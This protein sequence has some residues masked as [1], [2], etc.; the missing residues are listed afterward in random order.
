M[1]LICAK[2]SKL[3]H[4][5]FFEKD[6]FI[7]PTVFNLFSAECLKW[8]EIGSS[9]SMTKHDDMNSNYIVFFF[10]RV[11]NI[12]RKVEQKAETT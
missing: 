6:L 12:P 5:V 4:L 11:E 9:F 1:R 3:K 10:R 7:K 2:K 8:S